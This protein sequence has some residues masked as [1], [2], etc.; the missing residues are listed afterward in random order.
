MIEHE[1]I[2]AALSAR[3]DGEQSL[4]D[5][6]VVDAHLSNCAQCRAFFDRA[7]ALSDQLHGGA[8]IEPPRDLSEV[9]LA[10]VDDEWRRIS[11]RRAVFLSLGRV[12]LGVMAVV[13]VVWAIGLL[14]TS[15]GALGGGDGQELAAVVA[16][17]ASVR[18]GV[19]LAL[20]VTAWK[21]RL[22]PGV[23]LIVA[24]MFTFNV[25]FA[26][27]DYVLAAGEFS[28]ALVLVPLATVVA[29]VWTWVADQGIAVRRWWRALD[30]DPQ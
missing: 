29:L 5:D 23:L 12:A 28:P 2:Q 6:S 3:I 14:F 18:F 26:L 24:T 9:I 10:G 13:W 4:I 17:A 7:L 11:E 15:S 20:G 27:R 8:P 21:P 30:A 1:D 16:S 19:A 25:G 22:I